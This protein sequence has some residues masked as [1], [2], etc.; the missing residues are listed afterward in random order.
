MVVDMRLLVTLVCL[1]VAGCSEEPGETL[2]LGPCDACGGSCNVE[3]FPEAGRGHTTDPIDY[4]DVPP[5]TGT[6]ASCWLA[7]TSY[8]TEVPDERWLHNAEHGGVIFLHACSDCDADIAALRAFVEQHPGRALMSPY[9]ALP[10]PFAAVS[11]RHRLMLGCFDLPT[12]RAFYEENVDNAP[13]STTA[14]PPASC[15]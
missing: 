4:T 6:H 7:W 2:G 11:W 13:E 15:N 1:S 8:D 14:S 12:L 5:T 3:A 9:A 10:T